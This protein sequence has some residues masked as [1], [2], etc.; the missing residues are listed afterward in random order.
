MIRK[1]VI[2]GKNHTLKIISDLLLTKDN[3]KNE[4][5]QISIQICLEK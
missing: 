3:G 2:K 5:N 1:S 4:S